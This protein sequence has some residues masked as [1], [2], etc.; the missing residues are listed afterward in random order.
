MDPAEFIIVERECAACVIG[1][2]DHHLCRAVGKYL[3]VARQIGLAEAAGRTDIDVGAHRPDGAADNIRLNVDQTAGGDLQSICSIDQAVDHNVIDG[4][5]R[6]STACHIGILRTA[7]TDGRRR[8]DVE[9][10]ADGCAT[11][12]GNNDIPC[13]LRTLNIEIGCRRQP[14]VTIGRFGTNGHV[15]LADNGNGFTR[16]DEN[17]GHIHVIGH[18]DQSVCCRQIDVVARDIAD[19]H[20]IV[21]TDGNLALT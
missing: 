15:L 8:S 7:E 20:S 13:G 18:I 1:A 4:A 17:I 19:I 5:D 14:D 21:C 3:D 6:D 9:D 2:A 10:I 12:G 11:A 16:C